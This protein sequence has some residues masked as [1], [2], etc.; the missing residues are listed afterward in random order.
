MTT[1]H[2]I[3]LPYN[4]LGGKLLKLLTVS[5][6]TPLIAAFVAQ[7]IK[8]G[9][10][11]TARVDLVHCSSHQRPIRTTCIA[12]HADKTEDKTSELGGGQSAKK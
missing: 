6:E 12:K 5:A 10:C 3:N 1:V 4:F 2:K 8:A 7:K 11:T 9:V